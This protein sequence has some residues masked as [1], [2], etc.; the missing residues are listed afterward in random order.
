MDL[1]KVIAHHGGRLATPVQ[2]VQRFVGES[3]ARPVS[4]NGSQA[5]PMLLNAGSTVDGDGDL[6]VTSNNPVFEQKPHLRNK[7]FQESTRSV[8]TQT[9]TVATDTKDQTDPL[10]KWKA[11]KSMSFKEVSTSVSSSSKSRLESG[12]AMASR[13]RDGAPASS[14]LEKPLVQAPDDEKDPDIR[15]YKSSS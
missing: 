1:L 3:E 7:S 2:S 4:Y 9:V 5:R 14:T 8:E 12:E 6:N 11:R 10:S 13:S 15:S